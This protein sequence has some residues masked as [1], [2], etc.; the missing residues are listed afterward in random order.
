MGLLFAPQ[1]SVAA[2][3]LQLLLWA[4]YMVDVA[5]VSSVVSYL[6]PGTYHTCTVCVESL[7]PCFTLVY[8][9]YY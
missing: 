7:L 8:M 5:R 1:R 9:E 4:A 3:L 2:L 6:L